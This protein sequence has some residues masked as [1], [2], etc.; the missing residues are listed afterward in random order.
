MLDDIE[1]LKHRCVIALVQQTDIETLEGTLVPSDI[2]NWIL[3]T[4]LLILMTMA[5]AMI[6]ILLQQL[7]DNPWL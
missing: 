4:R 3:M 5:M 6:L 2:E 1:T 7:M